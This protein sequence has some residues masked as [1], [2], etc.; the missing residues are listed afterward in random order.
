MTDTAKL[1]DKVIL[2]APCYMLIAGW[3]RYM[4]SLAHITPCFSSPTHS[5]IIFSSPP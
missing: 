4:A 5:V 1:H 3:L 2:R